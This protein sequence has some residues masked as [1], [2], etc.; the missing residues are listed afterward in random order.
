MLRRT[1][2]AESAVMKLAP[3]AIVPH[4]PANDGPDLLGSWGAGT[5][6]GTALFGTERCQ[7]NTIC[8]ARTSQLRYHV[9]EA[10]MIGGLT[11]FR[12]H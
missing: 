4:G 6:I 11:V 3:A 9:G 8:A 1:R 7:L 5:E 10:A 2:D 12:S